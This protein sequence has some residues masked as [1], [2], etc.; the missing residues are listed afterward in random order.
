MLMFHLLPRHPI[1]FLLLLPLLSHYP[2]EQYLVLRFDI[3]YHLL[4]AKSQAQKQ[5]WRRL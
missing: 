1:I 2:Q 3:I 4:Q 5:S